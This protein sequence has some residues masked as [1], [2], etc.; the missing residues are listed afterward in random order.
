MN[1]SIICMPNI[2]VGDN[3]VKFEFC[4]A[5]KPATVTNV[6]EQHA[7]ECC[8][9]NRTS[10]VKGVTAL[11]KDSVLVSVSIEVL[12]LHSSFYRV[13]GGQHQQQCRRPAPVILV[14]HSLLL[15]A[16]MCSGFS[17]CLCREEFW[18][19]WDLHLFGALTCG[20]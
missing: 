8:S 10:V 14:H 16:V 4:T 20:L 7:E 2:H 19:S 12:A 3:F 11:M 9:H 13:A 1:S 18:S 5:V 17:V 15:Q 6:L